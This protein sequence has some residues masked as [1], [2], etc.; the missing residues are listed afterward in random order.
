MSR[1]A[2][3]LIGGVLIV[4]LA[5]GGFLILRNQGGGGK[6]VVLN[7]TVSN[8]NTM[9]PDHLVARQGDSVTINIT[10]DRTGEVHLHGYDIHFETRAGEVASQTFRASNSGDFEIEWE[11]TSTHLGDLAVNP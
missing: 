4:F 5:V 9:K 6:P 8:A 11:S 2:L 7:V 3:L 10:S 1:G